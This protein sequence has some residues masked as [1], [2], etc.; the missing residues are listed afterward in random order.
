MRRPFQPFIL[1]G[2][3]YCTMKIGSSDIVMHSSSSSGKAYS[4]KE[5]LNV[6][7]GN[8]RPGSGTTPPNRSLPVSVTVSTTA[9]EVS[10]SQGGTTEDGHIRLGPKE[11]MNMLLIKALIKALTGKD[12]DISLPELH[13]P[14]SA[15]IDVQVAAPDQAVPAQQGAGWG[16]EY[17]RRESLREDETLVF[18][19]QGTVKTADGAEL[20]FST[21]LAM[22]RSFVVENSLS[23][24][25]GDARKIDPL[26]INLDG[27]AVELAETSFE[28]DLNSDG[29]KEH[30]A[31]LKP[32][33]GFLALDSNGDGVISS[34][35]ELFGPASG[36]GFTELAA[37]DQD[38]NNWIDEAD[39]VYSRLRI[40]M[41][42]AGG[43]DTLSTLEEKNIGALFLGSITT[44]FDMKDASNT[45]RGEA[46]SAGVYL[47]ES[48][49]AG[50]LQQIDLTV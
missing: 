14:K 46:K 48:G 10:A 44:K 39:A 29:K 25:E 22:S 5:T 13:D 7:I 30:I 42:N 33:S 18:R 19:A 34:G 28:F 23:I 38:G 45:S 31:L 1:Y 12:I 16:V 15:V 50:T 37:F 26:V 27:K 8:E 21:A 6:W 11:R 43:E 36:N 49:S 32:G 4:R 41:K 20:R 40:W 3:E 17:D 24:R 35:S 47:T 2:G 9:V